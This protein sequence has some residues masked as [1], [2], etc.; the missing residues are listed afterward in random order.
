VRQVAVFGMILITTQ[1]LAAPHA[2][3]GA[4]VG[5]TTDQCNL[6]LDW[7]IYDDL[8]TL[9]AMLA[10]PTVP[11]LETIYSKAPYHDA[12]MKLTFAT[13]RYGLRPDAISRRKLVAAIPETPVDFG[14]CYSLAL[15]GQ[16]SGSAQ[17]LG[18][19]FDEF[20]G[21][22]AQVVPGNAA[23]LRKFLGLCAFA[24]G[25]V[26]EQLQEFAHVIYARDKGVFTK[27]ARGLDQRVQR[28][29]CGDW[30]EPFCREAWQE[31]TH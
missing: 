9:K 24:D 30:D 12:G 15:D 29:L 4:R 28:K 14:L 22:V 31:K 2:E 3:R 21:D 19:L 26:L 6:C 7:Y 27:V 25:D 13:M 1:V 18:G 23:G 17:S 11:A 20:L 8:P 16:T 10:A 5:Q